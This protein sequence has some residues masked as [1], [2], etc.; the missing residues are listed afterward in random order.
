[1]GTTG[2]AGTDR[3]PSRPDGHLDADDLAARAFEAHTAIGSIYGL[4]KVSLPRRIA[5]GAR[6]VRT[7]QIPDYWIHVFYQ[8]CS[9]SHTRRP[10]ISELTEKK[11]DPGLA[12]PQ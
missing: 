5:L 12:P 9:Y 3:E 10:L 6:L 8:H 1:M 7:N 4:S 11:I 2:T